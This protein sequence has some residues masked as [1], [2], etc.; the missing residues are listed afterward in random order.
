MKLIQL[1]S[2]TI[3]R[4]PDNVAVIQGAQG[5]TY[6]EL[7]HQTLQVAAR[8]SDAGVRMGDRAVIWLDNSAS[9]IATYLAILECGA[10]I[11]AAHARST[12]LDVLK[13]IQDVEAKA[14]I[15]TE[16]AWSLNGEA[17]EKS[18]LR[19]VLLP[20]ETLSLRDGMPR[21]MAPE[22]LAQIVYTSG[23]TGSPKGVM[24][25]HD[26]LVANTRSILASLKIQASDAVAAVLP[27]VFVYGN[28]VMLTHLAAG[29]KIVI[30]DSLLYPMMTVDSMRM[31]NVTGFSGVASNYA[32]LLRHTD[33]DSA[34]LPALRYFTSAGGPMPAEL[35]KKV[36]GAF[37]RSEFHVMYGQ[38]E[39]TAR[40]TMLP[41]GD[42]ERYSAS[43][44]L[45]V[46]GVTVEILRTDGERALPRET[47]E[48]TIMG[49]S[50]MLG[51][52]R[53]AAA[54][55]KVLKDGRLYTGDL[56]YMDE[57]GYLY[58]TG[59]NSEMI[60]SGAFRVSPSEIEEVL[61]Q[62]PDVYEAGVIGTE[63]ELLGEML[64]AAVVPKPDRQISMKA[65]LAHCARRL[66]PYK[67]PKAIHLVKELP[68]SEN[69]KVLRQKLR[70]LV[71]S[72]R[73]NRQRDEQLTAR[74]ARFSPHS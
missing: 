35:L 58:I 31:E 2:K 29:A 4:C 46:A 15:T 34:H 7:G 18:G 17:L 70:G 66:P 64:V 61:F 41:P 63:D 26:N 53:D 33:F 9:Y 73:E 23:T 38:T 36:R 44:G 39:A 72:L 43:A 71:K 6:G 74:P 54:S 12:A 30:A 47:G 37:P 59:R 50:V 56:G 1:I 69:G 65:V 32:F 5:W 45:P 3:S 16:A 60:K 21:E 68:K 49:P 24:L 40:I 19:S 22:E 67:R 28:S 55:A 8:L 25:S 27:F 42:L 48:I 62:H 20:Q 11:V 57:R 14:L 52:W 51:Y 13:I 10:V